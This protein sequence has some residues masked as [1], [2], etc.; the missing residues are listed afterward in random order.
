MLQKLS[1]SKL[2]PLA[3]GCRTVEFEFVPVVEMSFL[4]EMVIDR[5][6]D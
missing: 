6:V 1:G 3:Q 2:S 4:V 5:S